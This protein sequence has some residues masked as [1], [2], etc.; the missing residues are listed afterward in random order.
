MDNDVDSELNQSLTALKMEHRRLDEE[1]ST[2][3]DAV[4]SDQLKISRMKKKKLTI[5]D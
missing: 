3:A 2:L 5:K 1:I 4:E